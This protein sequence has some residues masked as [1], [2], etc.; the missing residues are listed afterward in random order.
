MKKLG[1]DYNTLKKYNP[2]LIFVSLSGYGQTG[3]WK[4]IA[5]HDINYLSLASIPSFG[6]PR[7]NLD[8]I[9]IADVAGGSLH[10]VIAIL[11]AVI[12]RNT[13]GAGQQIDLS[14]FDCTL[15]LTELRAVQYLQ[16]HNNPEPEDDLLNGG[17][18]YDY[19]ETKDGR[20][21][22]VGSLEPKFLKNLLL[23]FEIDIPD[24][25]PSAVMENKVVLKQLKS[26]LRECFLF[27]DFDEIRTKFE[28]VDACVE[29]VLTMA[30]T[31][32]SKHVKERGI[33]TSSNG[34]IN[35]KQLA[36]P[37]K[38]S[39]FSPTYRDPVIITEADI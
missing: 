10:S 29:P 17:S 12:S 31:F 20:Y 9:Q 3:E 23:V 39:N 22:S 8:G 24:L 2:K 1:I 15:S 36:H 37:I 5:G 18:Q 27:Y 7:P 14:M 32:D 33:V 16:T 13:S 11:S 38:Y 4:K 28:G 6:S 26:R 25:N 34:E 35:L 21:Y 30:E 19:Y